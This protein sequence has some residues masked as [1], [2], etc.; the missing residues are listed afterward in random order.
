MT[1]T[2]STPKDLIPLIGQELGSSD[3]LEVPQSDINLFADARLAN[4]QLDLTQ[5]QIYTL[6]PGTR[7]VL[8]DLKEPVTLRLFYS[9]QL[10]S[11]VP[12]YG[13]ASAASPICGY[14][15]LSFKV[16]VMSGAPVSRTRVP[17]AGD[18]A[19]TVFAA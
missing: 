19:A 18:C 9:R 4:L 1:T 15:E 16:S 10:G 3:W 17:A 12:A 7:Q 14:A 2:V 6:S 13:E 11:T 5:R 8:A